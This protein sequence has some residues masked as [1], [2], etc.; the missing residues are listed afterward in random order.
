MRDDSPIA[1]LAN[2]VLPVTAFAE[3]EGTLT[4]TERRV[5]KLR[6]VLATS[7]G[8]L[9]DWRI[10]AD[11]SQQMGSGTS[12]EQAQSVYE[13]IMTVVPFYRG[14]TYERLDNGGLQWPDSPET[15][16]GSGML[17]LKM[18]KKPLLLLAWN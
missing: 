2:V 18:L 12:Y 6:S 8:A 9:P 15:V 7:G 14:L 13:E 5:Q 17:T 16:E 11:L 10:L 1:E 4:N 3:Q